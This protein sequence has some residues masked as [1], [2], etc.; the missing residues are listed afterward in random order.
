MAGLA[1]STLVVE[2]VLVENCC[3]QSDC[4]LNTKMWV[5]N[6]LSFFRKKMFLLL[7]QVFLLLKQLLQ[8]FAYLYA[9]PVMFSEWFPGSSKTRVDLCSKEQTLI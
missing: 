3:S 9:D 8:S 7:K 6:M 2:D 4:H 1:G 5:K